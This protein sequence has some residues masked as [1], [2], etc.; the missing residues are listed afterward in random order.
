MNF[1]GMQ[2]F[3]LPCGI[4]GAY[5]IKDLWQCLNFLQLLKQSAQVRN[6]I[7]HFQTAEGKASNSCLEKKTDRIIFYL[8]CVVTG[9]GIQQ[10]RN[11]K[12]IFLQELEQKYN[13]PQMNAYRLLPY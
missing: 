4:H 1:R 7:E 12:T 13:P 6:I 10:Y 2:V 8:S 9:R 5:D 3:H 11:L